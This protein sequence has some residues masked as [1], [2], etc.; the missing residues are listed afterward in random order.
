[1]EG[2]LVRYK[3]GIVKNVCISG[4]DTIFKRN[5]DTFASVAHCIGVNG[6]KLHGCEM[7]NAME[8]FSLMLRILP[9]PFS[10]PLFFGDVLFVLTDS[11]GSIKNFGINDFRSFIENT[12][13]TLSPGFIIPKNTLIMERSDSMALED[14][15]IDDEETTQENTTLGTFVTNESS[16]EEEDDEEETL[17]QHDEIEDTE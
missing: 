15:E 6:D 8:K 2:V 5:Q 1:M 16:E 3:D 13:E 12:H 14:D 17:L 4:S 11:N 9:G 10:L 7:E